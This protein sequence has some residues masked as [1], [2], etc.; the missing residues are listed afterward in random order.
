[1]LIRCSS[2]ALLT[3]FS[4]PLAQRTNRS[5]MFRYPM[6]IPH[7]HHTFFPSRCSCDALNASLTRPSARDPTNKHW[8]MKFRNFLTRKK[9]V[10]AREEASKYL[11]RNNWPKT[12][13]RI[14]QESATGRNAPR[15][16]LKNQAPRI[17]EEFT[18]PNGTKDS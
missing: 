11:W 13:Q 12:G 4:R 16:V 7:T 10:R 18:Q 2:D 15:S 3:H 8:R 6:F 5:R 9:I 17:L 14:L 1:M